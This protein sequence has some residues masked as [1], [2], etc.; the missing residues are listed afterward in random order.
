MYPHNRVV[1]SPSHLG[2]GTAHNFL[3]HHSYTSHHHVWKMNTKCDQ[4]RTLV[5]RDPDRE[6]P[7]LGAVQGSQ[8][9][10]HVLHYTKESWTDSVASGCHF[11]TLVRGQVYD[12]VVSS[13]ACDALGAFV[14]LAITHWPGSEPSRLSDLR[15]QIVSKLG[16]SRLTAIEELPG[17]YGLNHM[18]D[19]NQDHY[20]TALNDHISRSHSQRAAIQCLDQPLNSTQEFGQGERSL[21]N[22]Q[23]A[24]LWRDECLL[25]HARCQRGSN[26]AEPKLP[27]RLVDVADPEHPFIQERQTL[28]PSRPDTQ[29]VALS[30]CWGQGKK[31]RTLR[32]NYEAFK[33]A[34]IPSLDLPQTFKDAIHAAH[35]LG[36]QYIWIDAL[37]I[38]QDDDGDLENELKYMGDIYRYAAL[39]I[40]AQGAASSHAGLFQSSR[41]IPSLVPCSVDLRI[42]STS[43]ETT[44]LHRTLTGSLA[45]KDY[46][47]SRGWI[48]QEDILTLRALKFSDQMSWRCMD[49]IQMETEPSP[50]ARNP[51]LDREEAPGSPVSISDNF[52]AWYGMIQ[53]YSDMELTF[54]SDVLRALSGLSGMFRDTYKTTYLAGLWK[55][56][57]VAGLCWY[58][59]V[60]DTRPV[61][62]SAPAPPTFATATST[63]SL[64]FLHTAPSWTWASVG[65]VRVRF[66]CLTTRATYAKCQKK[67]RDESL[68]ILDAFCS[69]DDPINQP[70]PSSCSNDKVPGQLWSL[71]IKTRVKKAILRRSEI[72]TYWRIQNRIFA[73]GEAQNT[74]FEK[75]RTPPGIYPRFPGQLLDFDDR[76][77]VLGDVSCD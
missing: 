26:G 24:R 8:R 44:V 3:P 58:I 28:P 57:L 9:L 34:G 1:D 67:P 62:T 63:P 55:E 35:S 45:V 66:A 47:N 54:P 71:R 36:Y 27:T 76:S 52:A 29:Y 30:Y 31:F 7:T 20:L 60:N 43:Q 49:A 5:F 2:R 72:Y 25:N 77:V 41:H 64:A 74:G 32:G 10:V 50:V 39:T 75:L 48:L 65:K 16:N 21:F 12:S 22:V 70:R 13:P 19:W 42:V 59:S 69:W 46:L 18:V 51:S 73:A 40:C 15:V 53:I 23:L 14:I 17:K 6:I 56:D 33:T 38:I 11:C 37:C 4:C 61:A 68:H